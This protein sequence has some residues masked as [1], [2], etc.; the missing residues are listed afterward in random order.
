VSVAIFRRRGASR[1]AARLARPLVEREITTAGNI[2]TSVVAPRVPVRVGAM[3]FAPVPT[4][5]APPN[6]PACPWPV[7]EAG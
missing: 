5:D 2:R 1:L 7:L 6:Q 3:M 4:P